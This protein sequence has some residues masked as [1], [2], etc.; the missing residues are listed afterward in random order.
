[1]IRDALNMDQDCVLHSTRH[2]FCTNLGK[3]G[4]DAFTIQ[5]LAG[6]SSITISQQYVH[7]DA[8][9]QQSAIRLLDVL[10]SEPLRPVQ[11]GEINV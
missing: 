6:H 8:E 2:T 3:A 11:T 7:S 10:I 5:K 9:V 4:A 1:V